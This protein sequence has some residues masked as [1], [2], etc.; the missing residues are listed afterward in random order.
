MLKCWISQWPDWAK[1]RIWYLWS[2]CQR[3]FSCVYVS[4]VGRNSFA[5]KFCCA[6]FQCLRPAVTS[7][8]I[9]QVALVAATCPLS[10][11]SPWVPS[12]ST[13]CPVIRVLCR[14]VKCRRPSNTAAVQKAVPPNT[15]PRVKPPGSTMPWALPSS[16]LPASSP[17]GG[18]P[19]T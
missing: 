17:S 10:K 19:K 2:T 3:M 16:H 9:L 14:V 1:S 5:Y 13:N 12:D 4:F 8:L 6:T 11:R 7:A 15:P 18:R